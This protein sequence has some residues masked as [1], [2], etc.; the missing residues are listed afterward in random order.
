MKLDVDLDLS[1]T[2]EANFLL[3]E[4]KDVFAWSYKG[5]PLHIVQHQ[6]ELDT[7]ILPSH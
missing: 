1:T 7:M 4:Y 2:T 6:I 3:R 5:I